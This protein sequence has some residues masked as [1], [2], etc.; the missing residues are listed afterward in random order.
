MPK[1]AD[2]CEP[3]STAVRRAIERSGLSRYE[4]CKATGIDKAGLSRFMTGERGLTTASLDKLAPLLGLRIVVEP[5]KRSRGKQ[6][7]YNER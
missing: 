1:K 2:N 6:A 4:I 7:A 3:I 5:A